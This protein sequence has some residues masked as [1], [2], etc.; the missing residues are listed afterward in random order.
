MDAYDICTNLGKK[1]LPIVLPS[2][3]KAENSSDHPRMFTV[4]VGKYEGKRPLGRPRHQWHD[5]IKPNLKKQD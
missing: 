3:V 2:M 1:N 4:F 5:N